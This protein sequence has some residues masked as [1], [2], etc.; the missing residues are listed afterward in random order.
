ME[1]KWMTSD[2]DFI[3][4]DGIL[5][6]TVEAIIKAKQILIDS[7]RLSKEKVEKHRNDIIEIEKQ[8]RDGVEKL[9]NE[10]LS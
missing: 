3:T 7:G 2:E 9:N 6:S 10:P 8:L 1:E 4:I 5:C